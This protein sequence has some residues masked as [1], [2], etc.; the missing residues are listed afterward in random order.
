MTLAAIAEKIGPDEFDAASLKKFL[1]TVEDFPMFLA[2]PL[3]RKYATKDAPVMIRPQIQVL[4][5]TKGKLETVKPWFN[6]Y[7]SMNQ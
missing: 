1:L 3:D 2:Q 6:P 5:Y 7:D 4:K